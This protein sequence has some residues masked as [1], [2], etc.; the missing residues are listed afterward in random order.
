MPGRKNKNRKSKGHNGTGISRENMYNE[1]DEFHEQRSQIMLKNAG[2]Q[3]DSSDDDIDVDGGNAAVFDL[4]AN[5]NISSSSS[6]SSDSDSD[7]E[8]DNR[9]ILPNKYNK[10]RNDLPDDKA[11]GK[12]KDFYGED[13]SDYAQNSEDEEMV[14]EEASRLQKEEFADIHENDYGLSDDSSSS[15]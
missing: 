7:D 12:K 15:K 5:G 3:D 13:D 6:S 9:D 2:V 10:D 8:D 11:W 4:N 14:V 1:V